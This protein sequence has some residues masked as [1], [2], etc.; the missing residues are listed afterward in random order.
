MVEAFPGLTEDERLALLCKRID[1]EASFRT[2]MG[3]LLGEDP[4]SERVDR[5]ISDGK[6]EGLR[7]MAAEDEPTLTPAE[8]RILALSACGLTLNEIGEEL[9]VSFE[10]A[11]SH[12]KRIRQKLGARNITHAV[13]LA[14]ANGLFDE[15]LAA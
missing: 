1:L 3:Q 14:L 2:W 10:T 4:Y 12:T 7:V 15:A 13:T 11:K 9:H 5:L 8:T 6:E